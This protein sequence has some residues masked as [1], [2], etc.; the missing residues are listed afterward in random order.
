[1][2]TM[3]VTV[4]LLE[5]ARIIRFKIISFFAVSYH[6]KKDLTL[7]NMKHHKGRYVHPFHLVDPSPW[8][9]FGSLA[10]F[11][12]AGGTVLML[13]EYTYGLPLAFC[14]LGLILITMF[15][16]WRDVFGEAAFGGFHTKKVSAGH[17]IGMILFIISEVMFFFAFFWAYFHS[18]IHP[19]IQIGSVWP[20]VGQRLIH[21]LIQLSAVQEFTLV[22]SVNEFSSI[23]SCNYGHYNLTISKYLF[24]FLE[25]MLYIALAS[26]KVMFMLLDES[27]TAL[28]YMIFCYIYDFSL[29]N[30]TCYRISFCPMS[31]YSHVNDILLAYLPVIHDYIISKEVLFTLL[32]STFFDKI[33]LFGLPVI[34][35]I[36]LVFSSITLM[37]AHT[38]LQVEVFEH[39]NKITSTNNSDVLFDLILT[40]LLGI[41]FTCFQ[42][43]EYK[44]AP[45]QLHDG[46][47]ASL[48]FLTTGFHGLH[49]V[50]GTIFL[51]VCLLRITNGFLNPEHHQAFIFAELYWHFVDTVW[52]FV[53][54]LFYVYVYIVDV[55][56]VLFR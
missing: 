54:C 26:L 55:P 4:K 2:I 10:I 38:L 53:F 16:W 29:F 30:V 40:I 33:R 44:H 25:S 9:F 5:L 3:F 20:P 21:P 34:N 1:M 43:F 46:I 50:I 35:T 42:V 13:Q 45:F 19:T 51:I 8:P 11:V 24:N 17:Q 14:G 27:I 6:L 31:Y 41:L 52:I 49:V 39:E 22:Q 37:H 12:L 48:F 47:F 28:N 36:I 18:A 23:S 56:K 15:A 32:Y 7:Q